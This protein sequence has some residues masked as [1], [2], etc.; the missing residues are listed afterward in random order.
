[1][2]LPKLIPDKD[3]NNISWYQ[4]PHK[5]NNDVKFDFEFT[6]TS[7]CTVY[8]NTNTNTSLEISKEGRALHIAYMDENNNLQTE[9]LTNC[10]LTNQTL[11]RLSRWYKQVKSLKTSKWY[12]I[13]NC[14]ERKEWTEDSDSENILL[15]REVLPDQN[16]LSHPL[17]PKL[18]CTIFRNI[19]RPYK[20]YKYL[21]MTCLT[22][23]LLL[24]PWHAYIITDVF[25]SA[26]LCLKEHFS[27]KIHLIPHQISQQNMKTIMSRLRCDLFSVRNDPL[28]IFCTETR[29]RN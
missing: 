17:T 21:L 26:I 25:I 12:N 6:C 29:S 7:D 1:M 2:C 4:Y 15:I 3:L 28:I 8:L 20:N 13:Y 24:R 27:L 14:V 23:C 19:T 11:L 10:S 9:E 16:H 5:F 22:I 18:H